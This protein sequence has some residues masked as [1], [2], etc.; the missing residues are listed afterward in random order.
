MGSSVSFAAEG[1][2]PGDI[3]YPVK[4]YVNE[5]VLGAV[6]VTQKAKAEWGI[7]LV[8]RRLEE[9]EKLAVT[10]SISPEVQQTA[11][12]NLI[13]YT[14]DAEARI[15][16]FQKNNNNV[17]DVETVSGK[18][19]DVLHRYEGTLSRLSTQ[20]L[21]AMSGDTEATDT[22]SHG[23]RTESGLSIPEQSAESVIRKI[24]A[25]R[26]EAD[27]IENSSQK[28]ETK[29]SSVAET[30]SHDLSTTPSVNNTESLNE[31]KSDVGAVKSS[32][33][34]TPESS[35][36]MKSDS[37]NDSKTPRAQQEKSAHEIE[38]NE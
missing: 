16:L 29:D 28:S 3:L 11:E 17:V 30:I 1:T 36:K 13:S 8:E 34:E 4:I 19:G 38:K 32:T 31:K 20:S 25:E 5:S 18:L 2:L 21:N 15:A 24:R 27:Q 6:A 12:Q 10:P 23:N 9:I 35:E 33:E 26:K 22:I 37:K 14:K 7:A